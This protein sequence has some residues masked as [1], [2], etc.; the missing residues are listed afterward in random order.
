MIQE[1]TLKLYQLAGRII[2]AKSVSKNIKDEIIDIVERVSGVK[3][4]GI[5]TWDE[6]VNC[7][8]PL[9]LKGKKKEQLISLIEEY[10]SDNGNMQT[11]IDSTTG[12]QFIVLYS[13]NQR[14]G[15]IGFLTDE[16]INLENFTDF[17]DALA[18]VLQCTNTQRTIQSQKQK[19]NELIKVRNRL[20]QVLRNN[21]DKQSLIE[22]MAADLKLE[23]DKANKANQAKSEFLS[24]MSHE[25]R[26]PLNAII[27]F[28]QLLEL[29]DLNKEQ[30]SSLSYILSGGEHLLT[31]INSLLDFSKIESGQV[32]IQNEYFSINL[33]VSESIEIIR[34]L[35][36][37]RQIRIIN[38]VSAE[39]FPDLYSDPFRVKQVLLNL[40]SNA[41]K[42]NNE[43]GKIIIECVIAKTGFLRIKVTDTGIGLSSNETVKIFEEFQRLHYKRGTIEGTGIGLNICK[44]LMQHLGGKI[45][46]ESKVN[47][48]SCFWIELPLSEIKEDTKKEIFYCED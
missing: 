37:K 15:V 3:T 23:A 40:F 45:G 16:K 14:V 6:D 41:I 20:E 43:A 9:G 7:Y 27:G 47:V 24:N 46:V 30:Q 33:L 32:D 26:T 21:M 22:K 25:L 8:Y 19:S 38:L 10:I 35:A 44:L 34:S 4:I 48:G 12:G 5:Y 2:P 39:S 11:S 36:N 18:H 13:C 29:D 1:G 28:A 42:Y 17:F 31:L